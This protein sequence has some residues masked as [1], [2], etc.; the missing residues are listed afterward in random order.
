VRHAW[1]KVIES[2]AGG[3][4]A[5]GR[6]FRTRQVKGDDPERKVYPGPPGWGMGLRLTSPHKKCLLRRF[7]REEAKV[8]QGLQCKK[9]KTT[10]VKNKTKKKKKKKKKK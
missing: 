8:H 3:S 7:K 9:K 10:R 2:C 5:T 4:V 6:A 1:S